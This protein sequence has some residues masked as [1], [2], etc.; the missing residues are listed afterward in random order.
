MEINTE[1]PGRRG[2]QGRREEG[3]S[4][5]GRGRGD[6]A[7]FVSIEAISFFGQKCSL[8]LSPF[9]PSFLAVPPS[10]ILN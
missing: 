8:P 7:P 5:G 2:A 4:A 9:T 10:M 6:L 1:E 3:I